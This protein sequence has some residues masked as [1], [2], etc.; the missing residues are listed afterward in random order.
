MDSL[1]VFSDDADRARVGPVPRVWSAISR[2]RPAHTRRSAQPPLSNPPLAQR[3][4]LQTPLALVGGLVKYHQNDLTTAATGAT[5]RRGHVLAQPR[6][7]ARSKEAALSIR[8]IGGTFM[9]AG[10]LTPTLRVVALTI[11]CS[12]SAVPRLW[13]DPVTVTSGAFN[14]FF[15]DGIFWGFHGTDGFAL[16]QTFA[17]ACDVIQVPINPQ[18]VVARSTPGTAVNLSAV[19]GGESPSTRFPLGAAK[20]II[21]GTEYS[22]PVALAGTFRFDV[23]TIVLPPP[24]PSRFGSGL[25]LRL[26]VP[27]AFNGQTT[28]F[29]ATDLD[30]TMPLFH[31]DLVGQG[32]A[33]FIASFD[34]GKFSPADVEYTFAATPEPATVG[35]LGF[36]LVGLV[37]RARRRMNRSSAPFSFL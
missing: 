27:F 33:N 23:P 5:S 7:Q 35:L 18:L 8:K 19:A 17:C 1:A 6:A 25:E 36:G 21:N 24:Q 16:L 34:E 4:S 14:L 29:A 20:G 2:R 9:T 22:S 37:G 26:E 12:A 28:G 15:S 13:A 32:T 11:V 30:A 10:V 31:V 3:P